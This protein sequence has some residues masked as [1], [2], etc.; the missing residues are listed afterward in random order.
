MF[1]PNDFLKPNLE[2]LKIRDKIINEKII[3]FGIKQNDSIIE[4]G[5]NSRD[6]SFAHHLIDK[7][8]PV[9]YLGIDVDSDQIKSLTNSVD[10]FSI[11]F[12]CAAAQ[13]II[14]RK[15]EENST[16][17]WIILSNLLD[18]EKYGDE[19]YFFVDYIIRN[20]LVLSDKGIII[21]FD[22]KHTINNESY[23][24]GFIM[25]FLLQSYNRYDIIRLSEE[26]FLIHIP[27][28][29]L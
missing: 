24:I 2:K 6:T 19:Q 10:N 29:Y 4:F 3:G 14:D 23:N 28:N 16:T 8:I 5:C 13:E 27:K 7:N 25:A 22:G 1:N 12:Q 9:S 15:L 17:D 21:S 11:K 18:K 26:Y 20:C